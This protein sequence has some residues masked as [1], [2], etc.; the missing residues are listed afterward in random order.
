MKNVDTISVSDSKQLHEANSSELLENPESLNSDSKENIGDILSRVP[1]LLLEHI[2][3]SDNVS[4]YVFFYHSIYF[5]HFYV[6]N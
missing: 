4:I 5:K 6:L 3:Y 1:K 2:I